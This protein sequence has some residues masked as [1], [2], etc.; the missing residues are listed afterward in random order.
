MRKLNIF[1]LSGKSNLDFYQGA[2]PEVYV[3]LHYLD[4]RLSEHTCRRLP[5]CMGSYIFDGFFVVF[6]DPFSLDSTINY[7]T[8]IDDEFN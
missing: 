5:E 6:V 8:T 3:Y 1:C 4:T 2:L 7:E